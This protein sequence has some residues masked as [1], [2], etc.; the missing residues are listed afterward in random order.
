VCYFITGAI[1]NISTLSD[2]NRIAIQHGTKFKECENDF[3]HQQLP[4]DWIYFVRDCCICD[5]DEAASMLGINHTKGRLDA[6]QKEK[7]IAKMKKKGWSDNKISHALE[8]KIASLIY[9]DELNKSKGLDWRT[10]VSQVVTEIGRFGILIHFDNCGLEYEN[11]QINPPI[12]VHIRTINEDFF[13]TMK[14]DTLYQFHC[15]Q[16]RHY[17]TA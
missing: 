4:D 6:I 3:V 17:S 12:L 13:R 15:K 11:L 9:K 2:L 10:L 7:E 5:C 1:P 14:V 16:N 8:Q